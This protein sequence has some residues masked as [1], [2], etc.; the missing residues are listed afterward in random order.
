M[1]TETT[2]QDVTQKPTTDNAGSATATKPD[3]TVPDT[4]RLEEQV[5]ATQRR[6]QELFGLLG[7][8][9]PDE[10]RERIRALRELEG[11]RGDDTPPATVDD[12]NADPADLLDE[13]GQIDLRK[14]LASQRKAAREEYE[15]RERGQRARDLESNMAT[16]MGEL[17]PEAKAHDPD[18]VAVLVRGL[19]Y[20]LHGLRPTDAP[21]MGQLR[22]AA[23]WFTAHTDEAV[24]TRL[25]RENGAA[26]DALAGDAPDARPGTAAA[27]K[28]AET[29]KDPGPTASQEERAAYEQAL[30][31]KA[32]Q[33]SGAIQ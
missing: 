14:V 12:D 7:A 3:A 2:T 25:A 24:K 26:A 33:A 31:R 15:A 13:D 22:E 5:K 1:S 27:A 8:K 6:E 16:V 9:N 32:L 11:Q 4:R 29:L 23:K 21:D 10:A 19:A 17:P 30:R 18:R 28:P 20:A